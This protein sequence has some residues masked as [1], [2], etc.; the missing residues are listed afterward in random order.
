MEKEETIDFHI[1]WAWS[2]ISKMYDRQAA[3]YGGTMATGYVLL[4]ID[5]VNGT[6]ST[7]LGPM[8]GMEPRSLTRVLRTLEERGLIKRKQDEQDKRKVHI[9]LTEEGLDRRQK[10]REAVIGFN[11]TLRDH[12]NEKELKTFL[13][14]ISKINTLLDDHN[15]F[16]NYDQK[17]Q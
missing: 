9:C 15:I 14:T 17:D 1:R 16:N 4:T 11:E 6:P 2:R 5:P 3:K 12:L 13:K 8:M 10:S 7:S